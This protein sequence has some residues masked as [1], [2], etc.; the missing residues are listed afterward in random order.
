MSFIQKIKLLL[1]IRKP[2]EGL[3]QEV[4]KVKTGWKTS[5][6]WL[7]IVSN[8]ITIAGALNGIIDAKTAGIILAILNGLYTTLRTIAKVGTVETP[9]V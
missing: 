8:L 7:T 9:K 1:K 3:I 6:F 2:A 4:G 5:E